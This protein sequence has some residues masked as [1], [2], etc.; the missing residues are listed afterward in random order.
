MEPS[1]P[2]WDVYP[3]ISPQEAARI[4]SELAH[5]DLSP[6]LV[7]LL[8][9]REVTELLDIEGFLKPL[10]I[11]QYP[12]PHLMAG[13]T[14]AVDRICKAIERRERV[15]VYGDFDCDGVTST[16]L[17]TTALRHFDLEVEPYVPNRVIEGYGL[18]ANAV[19]EIAARGVSLLITVDCGISGR[20]EVAEARKAGLDVI[21]TDHHHLPADL[22]EAAACINPKQKVEGCDCYHDLAGVGV[23]Y[24]LVRALVKRCGKPDGLRNLDLLGLVAIGTVADVVPLKG[25]NRSLVMHGLSALPRH[26]LPGLRTMLDNAGFKPDRM[27]TERIGFVIGPRLNAAGRMDDAR[28]AYQLLLTADRYEASTLAQQLEAHNRRRQAVMNAIVEDAR[29]RVRR[30]D[31]SVKMIVLSDRNWPSGVVGLVAGRLVEEF[32]RPAIVIEEGEEESRGSARSTPH[33][34]VV[35]SLTQV[36]DLLVRFGGHSAAA[37]FTLKTANIPELSLR[38]SQ[39]ADGQLQE[40]HLQPTLRA[41]AEL[42]LTDVHDGTLDGINRLAPFGSGN[43]SPMFVSMGVRV[44]DVSTVGE[45][46][47]HLKLALANRDDGPAQEII[48]MAYRQGYRA[49]AIRRKPRIDIMYHIERHEWRG[50]VSI[51]LRVRDIRV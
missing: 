19:R 18:N 50:N 47:S 30:M 36:K 21:V 39:I 33:F 6:L 12:D 28:I 44:L 16:A 2:R 32:G 24:Q 3:S 40:E 17:L 9:N 35:E 22:P 1:R 41:E 23:A 20:S 8:A 14:A 43:P 34:N 25:A 4:S 38:L 15:V 29:G 10:A 31:P 49:D 48:A 42:P 51:Q 45:G 37:G 7:Q 5:L 13:V 46:G 26:S 27:D 11:D